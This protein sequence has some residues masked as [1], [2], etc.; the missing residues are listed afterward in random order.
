MVPPALLFL[1]TALAIQERWWFY[2]KFRKKRV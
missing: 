2:K 1:K